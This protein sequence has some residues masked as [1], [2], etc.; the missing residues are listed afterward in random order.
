VSAPPLTVLEVSAEEEV[1]IRAAVRGVC[2]AALGPGRRTARLEDAAAL[3]G[4]LSDPVVS[5]PIYDIPRPIEPPV[6]AA[7][8]AE[9][10]AQQARGEGVL[11]LTLGAD[12]E[13]A[14]Y[15]KVTVWPDRSAAELAGAVAASRQGRGRGASGAAQMFDWM[16]SALRVR[17]IGLTAALDNVRSAKVIEAAGFRRMGERDSLRADGTVRRSLYWELR[18]EEWA[19]RRGG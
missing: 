19:H 14:G 8:I 7:W 5:G 13:V 17:L 4:L 12:G 3:A 10:L 6:M 9:S 15:S 1:A 2:D 11:L 18:R 16:F